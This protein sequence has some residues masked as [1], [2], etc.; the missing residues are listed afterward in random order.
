MAHMVCHIV[1]CVSALKVWEVAQNRQYPRDPLPVK[2]GTVFGC[3]HCLCSVD[4]KIT[5]TLLHFNI[6]TLK[7]GD[8]RT[9]YEIS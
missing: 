3:P 4:L 5:L 8:V 7:Y 6:S 2:S 1:A 9:Q